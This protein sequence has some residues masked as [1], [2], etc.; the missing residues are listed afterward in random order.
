MPLNEDQETLRDM[1]AA[2]ALSGYVRDGLSLM[3]RK[4]ELTDVA[5]ACYELASAMLAERAR[6]R[7][8]IKIITDDIET[9]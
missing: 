9:L 4:E 1:F 3:N 5:E 2:H 8:S 6:V 7:D